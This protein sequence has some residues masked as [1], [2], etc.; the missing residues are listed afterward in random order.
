MKCRQLNISKKETM[1]ISISNLAWGQS[2]D[3]E[4]YQ[5]LKDQNFNGLEIAPT[6]IFSVNP[7]KD[8]RI[9]SKWSSTLKDKY[10]LSISSI[11]SIWYGLDDSIFASNLERNKLIKYT[12]QAILFAQSINCHNLVFGCPKARN[13][14][15]SMAREQAESIAVDFFKEI[16]D[17]AAV[18]S[19]VFA[20]EANPVI[21]KTNFLNT[22]AQALEIVRKV[23]SLGCKIN[24]DLGT[25]IYNY[26]LSNNDELYDEALNQLRQA[27]KYTNHIHI[28]EPGLAVIKP[29]KLHGDLLKILKDNHYNGFISIEMGNQVTLNEVRNSINYLRSLVDGTL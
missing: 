4:M 14:P 27:I 22:T 26:K 20:L 16:G 8:L 6:R 29:R 3:E 13:I 23:N 1:K 24:L 9:A 7:Y 21:Y 17:Y 19:T 12:K 15:N 5:Y 2:F 10:N 25:V 18:H 28:S 11:Q